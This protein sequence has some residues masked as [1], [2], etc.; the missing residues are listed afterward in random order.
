MAAVT[1]GAGEWAAESP[2]ESGGGVGGRI[3]REP[4]LQTFHGMSFT[5]TKSKINSLKVSRQRPKSVNPRN[6]ASEQG[7]GSWVSALFSQRAALERLQC[8]SPGALTGSGKEL[9]HLQGSH[10]PA[11]LGRG[12]GEQGSVLGTPCSVHTGVWAFEHKAALR[13]GRRGWLSRGCTLGRGM[14]ET[15]QSLE[16]ICRVATGSPNMGGRSVREAPSS[17]C[18]HPNHGQPHHQRNPDQSRLEPSAP[19]CLPALADPERRSPHPQP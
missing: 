13:Q 4:K 5:N 10:R 3:A 12:L 1:G 19:L 15:V 16:S 8:P 9:G 6:G 2:P 11:C 18:F 7:E 17:S 14:H